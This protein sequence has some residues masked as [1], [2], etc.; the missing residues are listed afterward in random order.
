MVVETTECGRRG[1]FY[2]SVGGVYYTLEWPLKSS[3]TSSDPDNLNP[4]L[5]DL[6]ML[7]NGID[8]PALFHQ[9]IAK[10]QKLSEHGKT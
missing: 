5:V 9:E 4:G 8:S 3:P 1:Y 7:P 2:E 6:A 10:D